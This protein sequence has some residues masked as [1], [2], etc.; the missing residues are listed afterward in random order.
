MEPLLEGDPCQVGPYTLH[1]RLGGGGM[2]EVFLG[3]SPGGFPV[4]VKVVRP[5]LA[6]DPD[7]RRRFAREVAAA[8]KVGGFYTAAVLAADTDA[9][10]P[11]LATQYIQGPSLAEV[12]RARNRLPERTVR[13]LAAG[14]AEGLSAI[15]ACGIVHRDLKPG[16]VILAQDGPRLIDFGIA[17]AFEAFLPVT[18]VMGTPAF[19]S[20]EQVEGGALGPAS[21]VFSLGTLLAFAAS[22][23]FPFGSGASHTTAEA[24]MRR[25]PMLTGIPS[26]LR[27]LLTACLAK[28]P[29]RRPSPLNIVERLGPQRVGSG[30]L[31]GWLPQDVTD[32]VTGWHPATSVDVKGSAVGNPVVPDP[33]VG[34]PAMAA[35]WAG[36]DTV[37]PEHWPTATA[38]SPPRAPGFGYPLA[39][40]HG[41]GSGRSQA[42]ETARE[43]R[44]WA[45]PVIALATALTVVGAVLIADSLG[46]GSQSDQAGGSTALPGPTRSAG[47]RPGPTAG[48]ASGPVPVGGFLRCAGDAPVVGAY[49]KDEKN[50]PLGWAFI[51]PE[52]EHRFSYFFELPKPQRYLL[53]VGCGGTA[54]DWEVANDDVALVDGRWNSFECTGTGTEAHDSKTNPCR[55]VDLGRAPDSLTPE[56]GVVVG[57]YLACASEKVSGAYVTPEGPSGG[58][59]Y[60]RPA[61]TKVNGTSVQAEYRFTL[62]RS[63]PYKVHVGCGGTAD[64]WSISNNKVSPV[65]GTWNSFI[66]TGTGTG[67][68]DKANNPCRT[69]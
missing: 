43:R 24:I 66:C 12:I 56:G 15:H 19:M 16:N 55:R 41:P 20:P 38:T 29:E 39:V 69:L 4:A 5:E 31:S 33:A 60:V 50:E 23:V 40:S 48:D 7:F 54:T 13:V 22:G 1:Y 63:E 62:Q 61:P 59:A 64:N 18:Q 32:M 46:D 67:K 51:R 35:A 42:P 68:T 10:R 11:W 37:S 57:G 26:A 3:R 45:V 27:P 2:G 53:H 17:H 28:D 30:S 9:P 52:G 36:P 25:E 65:K 44:R 34:D 6:R 21:D 49:V 47:L 14:L 58:F 8:R